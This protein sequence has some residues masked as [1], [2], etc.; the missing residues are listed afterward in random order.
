M[1]GA[2]T[3]PQRM[4]C[5]GKRHALGE[6]LKSSITQQSVLLTFSTPIV[7]NSV[8]C[9]QLYFVLVHSNC[10]REDFDIMGEGHRGRS[11]SKRNSRV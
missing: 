1:S 11:S 9:H 2:L 7:L 4:A 3:I 6:L 10:L 8:Y 5:K